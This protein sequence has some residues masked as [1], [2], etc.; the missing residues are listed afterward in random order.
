MAHVLA[1][2][3]QERPHPYRGDPWPLQTAVIAPPQ[4]AQRMNPLNR[5]FE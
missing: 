4:I 1:P 3:R 5:C 2:L